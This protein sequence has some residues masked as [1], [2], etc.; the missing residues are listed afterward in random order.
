MGEF[1]AYVD[2][3]GDE[4]IK[5]GTEWLIITAVIIEK[6]KDLFISK[7]IDD[8]KAELQILPNKPFHWKEIRNKH[9][10]KKRLVIDRIAKEDFCSINIVVN[11]YDLE[12]IQVSS[13]MLF[14]YFCRFLIERITWY[15]HENM[16]TVKIIFSNRSNTSWNELDEYI[17]SLFASDQCEIR[18]DVITAIEVYDTV[19]KKMLQFADACA[20]S[21]GEALNKDQYGYI[22]ERFILK[23]NDKLYRRK[24]NLLSYGLKLFP[25]KYMNKYC[26]DYEWLKT[27]K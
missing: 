17:K 19:Q 6:E 16:G 22:D 15:V 25:Y 4:G 1:I 2:E 8:I 23:L 18:D 12:N 24:G 14:N 9:T 11:T 7:S 10:S 26:T 5:R 27:I 13:K 3:S 20:S 21:L